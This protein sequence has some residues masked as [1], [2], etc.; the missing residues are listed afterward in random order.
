[1]IYLYHA[2]VY[3]YIQKKTDL[4]KSSGGVVAIINDTIARSVEELDINQLDTLWLKITNHLTNKDLILCPVYVP[5]K[6]SVYSNI[7]IF[8]EIEDQ[9][10]VC[11][12]TTVFY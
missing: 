8:T 3:I 9:S 1:M 12:L 10:T 4:K 6:K 5:P 7:S 2:S 11:D